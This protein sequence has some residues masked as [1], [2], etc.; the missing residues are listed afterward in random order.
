MRFFVAPLALV[1]DR[2]I[3]LEPGRQDDERALEKL[4]RDRSIH[5]GTADYWVSYRL[6]FLF[7]EAALIVPTNLSEDRYKPHRDAFEAS[8]VVAYIYDP[9][10]SR[11]S[12]DA[13]ENDVI[14]KKLMAADWPSGQVYAAA[15]EANGRAAFRMMVPEYYAASCLSCHGSP[16]GEMD[17]TG[18]P[19]EGGHEK[20]LGG[21]ISLV[22]Y[23]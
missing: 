19:K 10:R 21:V 13:W 16:K 2:A 3:R 20:D 22:L 8:P 18:Y 17:I 5:A 1:H 12:P 9:R 11:E 14:V 7:R 23:K 6:T 15:A 4:L